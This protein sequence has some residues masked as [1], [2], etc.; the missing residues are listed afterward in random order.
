MLTQRNYRRGSSN[1]CK[2]VHVEDTSLC[3]H[4]L[5]GDWWW[6]HFSKFWNSR[7]KVLIK[8]GFTC[9]N[10][11]SINPSSRFTA[12]HFHFVNTAH[13]D[14]IITSTGMKES[15]ALSQRG[16]AQ[17]LGFGLNKTTHCA[18]ASL[19]YLAATNNDILPTSAIFPLHLYADRH[20]YAN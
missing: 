16:A 10:N 11:V 5:R 13:I 9:S 8:T 20:T 12:F 2:D 19:S 7:G 6:G 3:W 4:V 18:P 14:N 1:L 15:E 17:C